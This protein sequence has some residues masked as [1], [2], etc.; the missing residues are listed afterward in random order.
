MSI[1][2]NGGRVNVSLTRLD[3]TNAGRFSTAIRTCVDSGA[4]SVVVDLRGVETIDAS[5]VQVLRLATAMLEAAGGELV[6]KSPR[7]HTLGL[8]G[9]TSVGTAVTIC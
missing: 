5:G 2:R 6:L 8:L 3:S 7:C 1:A 4:R 9:L